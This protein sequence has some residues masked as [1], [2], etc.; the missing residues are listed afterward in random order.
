MILH[1][2]LESIGLV[3]LTLLVGVILG[4]IIVTIWSRILDLVH[5]YKLKHRFDKPPTAK[6]YCKDC[7]YHGILNSKGCEFPG[8]RGYYAP[9]SGFCHEA[10][11]KEREK[12]KMEKIFRR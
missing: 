10:E 4:L 11:P 12:S 5:S 8:R 7:K 3:T 2:I 1:R 6:C 9:S